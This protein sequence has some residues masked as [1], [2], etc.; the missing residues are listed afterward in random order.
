MT[1]LNMMQIK[2]KRYIRNI[3]SSIQMSSVQDQARI[4][5]IAPHWNTD[6]DL[7]IMSL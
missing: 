1:Q 7:Q 3:Q 5:A 4:C 2:L 6:C